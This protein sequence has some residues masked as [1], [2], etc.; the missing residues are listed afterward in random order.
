MAQK[1]YYLVL[2]VNIYKENSHNDKAH[3]AKTVHSGESQHTGIPH[4][5]LTLKIFQLFE[6]NPP[7][8]SLKNG[9]F[10]SFEICE[11]T[12]SA[13]EK[14]CPVLIFQCPLL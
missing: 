2:Y 11:T 14:H 13:L 4:A 9:S 1:K 3:G 7:Q 12:C 8:K 5:A 6:I 10:K